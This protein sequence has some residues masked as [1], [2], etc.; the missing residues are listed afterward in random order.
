MI[1]CGC[2]LKKVILTTSWLMIRTKTVAVF[3]NLYW[4]FRILLWL[5]LCKMGL[6][7]FFLLLDPWL[8]Y[9]LDEYPWQ[10]GGLKDS[11]LILVQSP[12]FSSCID[13]VLDVKGKDYLVKQY[14]S[15]FL[16]S[17]LYKQNLIFIS[18]I[19][20]PW[21]LLAVPSGWMVWVHIGT[22]RKVKL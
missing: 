15:A 7:F 11:N 5:Y 2:S 22:C 19:K 8:V 3:V 20:T 9:S 12:G 6:F 16:Y 10:K 4:K 21:P 1:K 13:M 14:L 18:L 17:G